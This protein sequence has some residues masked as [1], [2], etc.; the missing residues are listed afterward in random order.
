MFFR[1]FIVNSVFFLTKYI[2]PTF[3]L[4]LMLFLTSFAS[5][6]NPPQN[7]I[8][9]QLNQPTSFLIGVEEQKIF[10]LELKQ[11]EYIE[12]V[13]LANE[14]LD[15]SF[16]LYD[17]LGKNVLAGGNDESI[18]FIAKEQGEYILVIKLNKSQ[19]LTGFHKVTLQYGNELSLPEKAKIDSRKI[20]GYFIK[21]FNS[22]ET[23]GQS[24]FFI[25]KDGKKKIV[26]K[27]YGSFYF[28]DDI[29][30][31]S[32]PTINEKRSVRLMKSALDKTGDGVPDIAIGYYSGRIVVLQHY[33]LS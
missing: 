20:N 27:G 32:F 31:Y 33:F 10:A 26:L 8:K 1:D 3:F 2:L 30:G 17:P 25:E 9:L 7:K 24:L 21:I 12:I 19:K 5:T 28:C 29:K 15:L 4:V 23:E 14:G 6:I 16:M 22:S 11:D 18:P 13:F